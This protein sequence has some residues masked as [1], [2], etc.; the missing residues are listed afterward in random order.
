[1]IGRRHTGATTREMCL[2]IYPILLSFLPG[3]PGAVETRLCDITVYVGQ[4]HGRS[5]ATEETHVEHAN[6]TQTSLGDTPPEHQQAWG[7][8]VQL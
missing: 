5:F 8:H 6:S 4:E 3:D 7:E 1:M 2:C